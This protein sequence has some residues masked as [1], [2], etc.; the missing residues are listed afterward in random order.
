M[1]VRHITILKELNKDNIYNQ[2]HVFLTCFSLE[3]Y[4]LILDVASCILFTHMTPLKKSIVCHDKH[5]LC[6]KMNKLLCLLANK[7]WKN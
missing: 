4:Q 1:F 2:S 5:K 6:D 7:R 3:T